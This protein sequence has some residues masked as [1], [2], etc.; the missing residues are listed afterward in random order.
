MVTR[1]VD[2]FR[3][4]DKLWYVCKRH[5]LHYLVNRTAATNQLNWSVTSGNR[6]DLPIIQYTEQRY[7]L[8]LTVNYQEVLLN[9]ISKMIFWS[10]CT[11]KTY[12]H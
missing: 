5:I 2:T 3:C 8:P 9:F 12:R 1:N 6:C 11:L 4:Y 10:I 7:E